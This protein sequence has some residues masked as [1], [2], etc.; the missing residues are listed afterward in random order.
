MFDV[1]VPVAVDD[2][3]RTDLEQRGRIHGVSMTTIYHGEHDSVLDFGEFPGRWEITR[4]RS[5][6]SH[7]NRPTRN[8]SGRKIE[9]LKAA[10]YSERLSYLRV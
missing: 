1:D 3:E 6:E 9:R 5:S 7:S 4:S 10:R 8:D 2:D